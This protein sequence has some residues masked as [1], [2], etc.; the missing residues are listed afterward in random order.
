MYSVI[1]KC[2]ILNCAIQTRRKL[3][4]QSPLTL[5]RS[6]SSEGVSSKRAVV[7]W[8]ARV[9]FSTERSALSVFACR[10]STFSSVM[11]HSLSGTVPGFLSFVQDVACLCQPPLLF[12]EAQK[13]RGRAAGG[14][15]VAPALFLI[16]E[17]FKH[18]HVSDRC[19]H[20]HTLWPYFFSTPLFLAT[21]PDDREVD[22][23]SYYCD[24]YLLVICKLSV[25]F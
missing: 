25:F 13:P 6:H 22:L 16:S 3:M 10:P 11:S 20:L 4:K 2:S 1:D 23:P 12:P 8:T 18:L 24:Y 17:S 7:P 14:L 15:T 21:L 9:T 5:Q 19:R